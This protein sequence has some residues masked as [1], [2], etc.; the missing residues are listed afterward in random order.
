MSIPSFTKTWQTLVNQNPGFTS[1]YKELAQRVLWGIKER[2]IGVSS[3]PWTVVGSSDA[4]SANLSGTDLW[5]DYADL[6]WDTGDHSWIVLKQT[7][8]TSNFQ[9]C[10]SLD[11]ADENT[12]IMVYSPT[13]GFTG[14]TISARPTATDEYVF[15]NGVKWLGST[16]AS[17]RSLPFHI[18]QSSDGECTRVV[19]CCANR[20]VS[21]WMFEKPRSPPAG[22]TDPHL[23]VFSADPSGGNPPPNAAR[24][25]NLRDQNS[26][27]NANG[28]TVLP[29][30]PTNTQVYLSSEGSLEG[31]SDP[32]GAM[33]KFNTEVNSISEEWEFYPIGIMSITAP[34]RGRLGEVV[35]MWYCS[36]GFFGEDFNRNGVLFTDTEDRIV[37]T[38]DSIVLPWNGESIP[39]MA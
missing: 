30:G 4:V 6:V 2:L 37:A 13:A 29:N 20:V 38:F 22:W 7:G 33:G 36:E 17:F 11:Q 19:V 14:G 10:I 23:V 15:A 27:G 25:L 32:G 8:I 12:I 21:L 24:H 35:D 1:T 5:V 16:S 28:F 9:L 31:G 18:F 39:K 26:A 34:N 3:G